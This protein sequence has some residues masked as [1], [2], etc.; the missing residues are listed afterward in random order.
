MNRFLISDTHFG[1]DKI[2]QYEKRPFDN[3]NQMNRTIISNWNNAVHCEDI[4]YHLGDF[5]LGCSREELRK[6]IYSLNGKIILVAGNHD[7][8]DINWYRNNVSDKIIQVS[9]T[10]IILDEWFILSHEP[11]YITKSELFCNIYG[12]VHNDERY[13]T[14]TRR[15]ACVC[16]ERFGYTP[17]N[18]EFL[19]YI[20]NSCDN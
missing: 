3:A 13:R 20:M 12:H 8:H 17:I 5:Q 15:T 1:H 7:F 10:P 16:C 6:I 19:K 14:F 2:I 9:P 11:K 18:F 4:V